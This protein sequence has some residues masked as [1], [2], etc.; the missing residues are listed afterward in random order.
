MKQNITVIIRNARINMFKG[1]MRL[2]VDKWGRIEFYFIDR[3]FFLKKRKNLNETYLFSL[4]LRS[5]TKYYF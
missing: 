5:L 2:A 1:N 4:K 3:F